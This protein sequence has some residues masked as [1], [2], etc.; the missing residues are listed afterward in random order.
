MITDFFRL[1]MG[2]VQ[3]VEQRLQIMWQL[4]MGSLITPNV[5]K[6]LVGMICDYHCQV[7][8]LAPDWTTELDR[9]E[10]S[11]ICANCI[12]FRQTSQRE[13][14]NRQRADTDM[15]PYDGI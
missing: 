3:E 12:V 5:L 14:I 13:L 8:Q 7:S 2:R 11:A 1:S 4:R 6:W 10:E 9:C 15:C